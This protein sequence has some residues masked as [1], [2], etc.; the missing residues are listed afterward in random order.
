MWLGG[1]GSRRGPS[2]LLRVRKKCSA[3]LFSMG[4]SRLSLI[5]QK[6]CMPSWDFL[7]CS[8]ATWA[9]EYLRFQRETAVQNQNP[10]W[11]TGLHLDK[12]PAPCPRLASLGPCGRRLGAT[13]TLQEDPGDIADALTHFG[14]LPG[15]SGGSGQR[16]HPTCSPQTHSAQTRPCLRRRS[17]GRA[18]RCRASAHGRVH[19]QGWASSIG[20]PTLPTPGFRMLFP[21]PRVPLGLS[22]AQRRG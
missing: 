22:G 10:K 19:S 5:Y 6:D 3:L 18:R 17:L 2:G 4:A 7:C 20:T 1:G 12:T 8:W 9:Q 13:G 15:G 11:D 14:A 21:G 16:S